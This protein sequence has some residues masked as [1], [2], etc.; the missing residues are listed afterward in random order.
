MNEFYVGQEVCCKHKGKGVVVKVEGPT[1]YPVCVKFYSGGYRSYT[2][3]GKE[4]YTNP[5]PDITP[6]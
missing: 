2:A 4:Y 1:G 5:E 3:E 6:A